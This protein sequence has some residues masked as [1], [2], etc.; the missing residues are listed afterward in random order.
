MEK[1]KGILR[2]AA[3]NCGPQ[4]PNPNPDTLQITLTQVICHTASPVEQSVYQ[5]DS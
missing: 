3:P 2:Q 5:Q 4:G 1:N